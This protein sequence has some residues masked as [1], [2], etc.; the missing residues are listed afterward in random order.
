MKYIWSSVLKYLQNVM[1]IINM[2][3]VFLS[4]M[5]EFNL[6]LICDLYCIKY[7]QFKS[8]RVQ[9]GKK[10]GKKTQ[11]KPILPELEWCNDI[12]P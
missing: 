7:L 2:R 10:T 3:F 5:K 9:W 12:H 4:M 11:D 6:W 1:T 8:L